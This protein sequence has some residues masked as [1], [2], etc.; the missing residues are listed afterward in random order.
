MIR[1]ARVA[2]VV[3][4]FVVACQR[5][6]TDPSDRRTFPLGLAAM[7][8]R[9]IQRAP[10][11]PE[12]WDSPNPLPGVVLVKIA[13]SEVRF[14]YRL[15]AAS[16][17]DLRLRYPALGGLPRNVAIRSVTPLGATRRGR[18]RVR[19]E[20]ATPVA[21]DSVRALLRRMRIDFD[22]AA[23]P[24]LTRDRWRFV[25]VELPPDLAVGGRRVTPHRYPQLA[26]ES[27]LHPVF[28]QL[29]IVSM[30][31]VF[32]MT[33]KRRGDG[34]IDVREMKK[35]VAAARNRFPI[36]AGR[37]PRGSTP[38]A[39]MENW[40]VLRFDGPDPHRVVEQLRG[41]PGI[42]LA[43]LDYEIENHQAPTSEPDYNSQWHLFPASSWGIDA[44]AAWAVTTAAATPAVVAVVDRGIKADLDEFAG[45]MWR[46]TG[47]IA[48]NGI[49]DDANGYIDDDAGIT[50]ADQAPGL[51][52]VVAAPHGTMVGALISA[53]GTNG[54]RITGVAG[55]APVSLMN[56]SLGSHPGCEGVA[57]GVAY[58]AIQGADV[59]NMSWGTYPTAV[60]WEAIQL[61]QA[62]GAI[63][64][65]SAGNANQR[66]GENYNVQYAHYP[67]SWPEVI[68]VGASD[69]QGHRWVAS[70]TTG[71]NWGVHLDLMAPGVAVNTVTYSTPTQ[72]N[73][74]PIAVSGT[75]MSAAIV[76]GVAAL[77][78]SNYPTT[79]GQKLA[80]W[81]QQTTVDLLD[82]ENT[83]ANLAGYDL[84]SGW[85]L[86]N[87][88][89]ATTR[90]TPDPMVLTLA[91]ERPWFNTR[92]GVGN[93]VG[94]T[95]DL[96]I[97]VDGPFVGNWQLS[98]GV[99]DDP[100][101]W[102]SLAVPAAVS[103]QPIAAAVDDW[104]ATVDVDN[105]HR[106]LDTRPLTNK[107]IHT[108]RLSAQNAAGQTYSVRDWFMPLRAFI[109]YPAVGAVAPSDWIM[110]PIEAVM[111]SPGTT[112]QVDI[113]LISP[114]NEPI[115]Q[116]STGVLPDLGEGS[117]G[118]TRQTV[119]APLA[120]VPARPLYP[121]PTILN[122][123]QPYPDRATR[124]IVFTVWGPNG[125]ATIDRKTFYTDRFSLDMKAGWPFHV[126]AGVAG[127]GLGS[128]TVQRGVLATDVDGAGDRRVFAQMDGHFL[129]LRADGTAMWDL[130]LMAGD[131]YSYDDLLEPPA[132]AVDDVDGDA[133]KE[134]AVGGTVTI[135]NTRH[136]QV[137]LL[138]R[139]GTLYGP[140]WPLEIPYF[141]D[142]Y[143]WLGKSTLKVALGDLDG[144][145]RKEIVFVERA[146]NSHTLP[147]EQRGIAKVHVLTV[148]G[149]PLSGWPREFSGDVIVRVGDVSGDGKADVVVRTSST[150][151]VL[152]ATGAPLPGWP[153]ARLYGYNATLKLEQ[154]DADAGLELVETCI[155]IPDYT[156]R[157]IDNN[158]T[159]FAGL[160]VSIP[161]PVSRSPAEVQTVNLMSYMFAEV[162]Q[163]YG[164]KQIVVA[165]DSVEVRDINGARAPGYPVIDLHGQA[166]G[167][168][169]INVNADPAPE[170]VVPVLRW[171]NH[172]GWITTGFIEIE[173]YKLDGSRLAATD[174]RWPIAVPF[175]YRL[176]GTGVL[177]QD[178]DADG[179]LDV[180]ISGSATPYATWGSYF[181][182]GFAAH[183][184]ARRVQ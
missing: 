77:V 27:A 98:V 165:Y 103:S 97:A 117:R 57:E 125:Q 73:A 40:F 5:S 182:G 20:L 21:A 38:P 148:A 134:I 58:A 60:L 89:N 71:S 30:S 126:P 79:R 19:V 145:G 67:S 83:G 47:E 140:G 76:S 32:P 39:N 59:V 109:M 123:A 115:R 104:S 162:A 105:G 100:T 54:I 114:P 74:E 184:E 37:A 116:W 154:A 152:D 139:D 137:M 169:V 156:L 42:E 68:S 8:D 1:A 28:S 111:Q 72:T 124:E 163:L 133:I 70:A 138:R 22:E 36:R 119:L 85:G 51:P 132:F 147:P 7:L 41:T 108:L 155:G 180:V 82:P 181:Y 118:T 153:I 122:T 23:T 120:R 159:T 9:G 24:R 142:E 62:A 150:I 3:A 146:H 14:R 168:K 130:P 84:H 99:G 127:Q 177:L 175:I 65:A 88:G 2:S 94:P 129:S 86:V 56:V 43:T 92:G 93:A 121:S 141:G 106:Y 91:M 69:P 179:L 12:M 49:D 157:V 55:A 52:P 112:Y 107:Q 164:P 15:P 6:K 46:N 161:G 29:G 176:G 101:T 16:D 167:L 4:L 128:G 25:V 144:D 61:G 87:V 172:D 31:R 166:L 78:L 66:E 44:P 81:L 110:P 26:E 96:A 50:V 75:S 33:E 18:R 90:G 80:A 113:N 48:G 136:N 34:S 149:A 95:P 170:I 158:G 173:A 135:G 183:V 160:P 64:V 102:T 151:Q 13:R 63:H 10:G 131:D 171:Q 45:R 143:E 178:I 11:M 53:N 174:P 17:A 35:L